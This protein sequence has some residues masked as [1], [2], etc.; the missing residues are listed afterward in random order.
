M[1]LSDDDFI[2]DVDRQI[3]HD[4]TDFHLFSMDRSGTFDNSPD[5][6]MNISIRRDASQ[7]LF[8]TIFR[9]CRRLVSVLCEILVKV[10]QPA[11]PTYLGEVQPEV[12]RPGSCH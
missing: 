10:V 1:T 5:I 12:P 4:V 7:A 2:K 6:Q 11:K 8:M 9:G 3:Q